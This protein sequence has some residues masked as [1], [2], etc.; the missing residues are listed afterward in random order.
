[1]RVFSEMLPFFA[2]EVYNIPVQAAATA[3]AS[4]SRPI[5]V[6]IGSC[7]DCF[8]TRSDDSRPISQLFKNIFF[9]TYNG[10]S[11]VKGGG[12]MNSFKLCIMVIFIKLDPFML[13]KK[14]KI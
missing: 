6:R 3:S 4:R 8:L 2:D 5:P 7:S 1:M 9:K 10:G 11:S 14:K 13:K 12:Y